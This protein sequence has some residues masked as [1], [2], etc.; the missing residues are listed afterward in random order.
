MIV[1]TKGSFRS[2]YSL[3]GHTRLEDCGAALAMT[4]CITLFNWKFE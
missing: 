3:L 2:A 1:T 4:V